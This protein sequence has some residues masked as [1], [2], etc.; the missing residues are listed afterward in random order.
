MGWLHGTLY[1][2]IL[3]ARDLP[4]DENLGMDLA[5]KMQSGVPGGNTKL[6][7]MFGSALRSVEKAAAKATRVAGKPDCYTVVELGDARVVRTSIFPKSNDPKWG[8]SFVVAVAHDVQTVLVRVKDKDM[9]GSN[10]MGL[11]TFPVDTLLQGQAIQ[12][13]HTLTDENGRAIPKLNPMVNF[14]IQYQSVLQDP[15]YQPWTPFGGVEHVYF[16]ARSGNRVTM[17]KDAHCDGVPDIPLANGSLYRPGNCYIDMYNSICAAKHFIYICGWSIYTE[18]KLVRDPNLP[19]SDTPYP[20]LG[21][22]LKSKA[23]EGVA[24]L[25]MVW[26]D[27]TNNLNLGG[28]VNTGGI[29]GTH[30]EDTF[31]YFK[32]TRVRCILFPREASHAQESVMKKNTADRIFT[33]H[34]KTIILDE[35]PG[36]GSPHPPHAR[37]VASYLGGLDLCNGRYDTG[38]HSIFRTLHTLHSDDLHQPCIPGADIKFGGPRQPW[39]DI[40]CR[41]EGPVAWDVLLNFEQRWRKQSGCPGELLNM[42]VQVPN[43]V[44]GGSGPP[45]GAPATMVMPPQ[46]PE[47]WQVQLLR[48]IDSDSADGFPSQHAEASRLGL[49]SLK[50]KIIDYSIQKAYIT[51]IRRAQH[52]IY[53]ENQYF[54]GSSHVWSKDR[55]AGANHLVAVELALKIVQKINA[56]ERFMAYIVLP[57][58]PEGVPESGACQEILHWQ[59]STVGMMYSLIAG[60]I[61]AQGMHDAHPTDYLQF[62]APGNREVLLPGEPPSERKAPTNSGAELAQ[63]SRRFMVYVHSKMMIVDDEYIIIG[64]ANINQRS[65][66]GARDTEIAMGAF[67]NG[68]RITAD[69]TPDGDVHGFRMSLWAEHTGI[70]SPNFAFPKD[71]DCVREMRQIGIT[72]WNVFA[73]PEVAEMQGHLMVYPYDI[74]ANGNVTALGAEMLPDTKKARVLGM[75]SIGLPCPLTT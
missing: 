70:M 37:V 20:T 66:D 62:F 9:F 38:T 24:V 5:G 44:F 49:D 45:E 56:R 28:M 4:M 1:I 67:Q 60:A 39:H 57:L 25:L 64:S 42:T 53:I 65:L 22:L 35:S 55:H 54:L 12:G 52:F 21:E 19:N 15:R 23:E 75:K 34:Q 33:H 59:A 36:E 32:N 61:K 43:L 29:M 17:Y 2:T 10:T 40:H 11:C 48:S 26:D 63:L 18:I 27:R 69:S 46:D 47:A 7:N 14:T 30:D 73:A 58:F 71:L 74:D 6:G 31:R 68:H 50:G 8:E 41:L 16:P 51:A 3:E 13:W 72:N